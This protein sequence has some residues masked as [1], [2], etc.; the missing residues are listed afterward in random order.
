MARPERNSVDYFPFYC[1]EGNKMFYLEETYGNDG[2]ATFVKLLRELAKTEYHYLNL[3]K[4][5]TMMYLS[6]KCKVQKTVLEAIINDLVDLGKFDAVLWKENNIVWCQ[7]FIESVQDAYKKRNNNCIT[8]EGLLT[9]LDSLG[10]RKLQ[11]HPTTVPV[12]T[13]RKEKK[14]KVKEIKENIA[15]ESADDFLENTEETILK[16]EEQ[17]RKKVAPK[18]E[19]DVEHWKSIV[20]AWFKFYKS[21]FIIDPTFNAAQGKFLKS[22]IEQFK[23]LAIAKD[24]NENVEFHWEEDRAIRTF[25][26]FLENAWQDKWLQDHFLLK[27]L[28]SNFDSIISKKIIENGNLQQQSS[29]T[30]KQ[31]RFSSSEA[32]KTITG[33]KY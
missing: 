33:D 30:K 4:P 20:D 7:D 8:F 22:I 6:A 13:Q 24:K 1:E 31:F 16:N 12:N 29:N 11:K 2:F 3:S 10:I 23:N 19:S 5:S 25:L 28:H 17:K 9:L 26:K 18:K 32:I 21:K 27:N 14:R 15:D